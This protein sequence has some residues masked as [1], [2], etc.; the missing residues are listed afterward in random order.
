M[1]ARRF[2]EAT[3]PASSTGDE[4]ADRAPLGLR[5]Y[6][7]ALTVPLF[8]V[9]PG[10]D[11][12]QGPI[13]GLRQHIDVLP[14][15]L[16]ILGYRAE[17]DLPGLSLLSSPGHE[18]LYFSCSYNKHCLALRTG[19]RKVIYHYSRRANELFD[20]GRDPLERTDGQWAASVLRVGTWRIRGGPEND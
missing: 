5:S 10:I 15:V 8:L 16:E 13:H 6:D 3:Q 2:L 19:D 14:T 7:E 1:E 17:G 20:L 11:P 9:G 12:A 18:K 4:V